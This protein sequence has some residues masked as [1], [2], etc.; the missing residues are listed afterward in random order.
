MAVCRVVNKY[1]E[2]FDINIQRGT[3]WGNPYKIGVDGDKDTVIDLYQKLLYDKIRNKEI[4]RQHLEVLRGMRLGCTC[5][6]KRC[7]GTIL[8]DVVNKVFGDTPPNVLDI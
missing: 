8:A 5:L 1:N 2:D 6:P 4:T 3:M 7:H